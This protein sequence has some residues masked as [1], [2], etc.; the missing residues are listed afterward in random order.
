MNQDSPDQDFSRLPYRPCVG[1]VLVN[2]DGLVWIGRRVPKWAGDRSEHCWQM[3]QGGIDEGED[4]EKAA[5]RE[6]EEEIGTANAEIIAACPRWLTY[7]LPGEALGIAL[8]GKY[9]GQTQKWFAMRFLGADEEIDISERNGHKAEFREW[10]WAPM[11]EA[12][13]AVV[14]FKRP[15]YRE[16][17]EEFAFLLNRT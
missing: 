13:E 10:R 15:V 17:A 4:P 9:R 5:F 3:P 11:R 2:S 7:D 12:V 8:K 1:V 14:P 16:L 6:L